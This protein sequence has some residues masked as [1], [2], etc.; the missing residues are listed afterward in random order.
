MKNS[1]KVL[2]ISSNLA[3]S[4]DG[5]IADLSC[6]SQSLGTPLDRK[7]M[8]KIRRDHQVIL[9]GANTLR[10]F[11]NPMCIKGLKKNHPANAIVTRTGDLPK[12]SEF[13]KQDHILRFV[14]TTKDGQKKALQAAQDR[15]FVVVC[16]ENEVSPSEVVRH[17]A[18]L[19][20]QKILVE[21]GGELMASFL[22]AQWVQTLHVT[23]T[24]KILGG[25]S[26]PTLVGGLHSLTPWAKLKLLQNKKVKDE[27]YLKYKVLG[28]KTSVEV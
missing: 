22:K 21:G 14:F 12:D 24:P 16:G 18:R 7:T 27:I 28:A 1:L 4:L 15:A 26:N 2:K 17:L 9:L 19:G 25:K 5:K 10:V 20:Y 8:D 13:W 6:P 3:I 23:L 11:S